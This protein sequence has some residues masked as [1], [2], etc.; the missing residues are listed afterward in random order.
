MSSIPSNIFR[1]ACYLYLSSRTHTVSRQK[2]DWI[3]WPQADHKQAA[4]NL[5][6]NL[7]RIRRFQDEHDFRLIEANFS[8]V[9]VD[10]SRLNWDLATVIKALKGNEPADISLLCEYYGGDLLADIA[11]SSEPFEDWLA[12]R[13]AQL[14][15]SV[16]EKLELALVGAIEVSPA[17]RTS[18]AHKLLTID[19]SNEQAFRLLMMEAA[20]QRDFARLQQIF[21][22]YE[23][24]LMEEFGVVGSAHTRALYAQL[25]GRA[26]L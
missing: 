19:A 4:A 23:R 11:E 20:K 13:R 6:Q 9:H 2:L 1:I 25:M 16:I 8:L 14:R 3:F 7:V 15:E 5:R 10:P 22:R 18:C 24:N 26:Q 12:E 21:Q 17:L